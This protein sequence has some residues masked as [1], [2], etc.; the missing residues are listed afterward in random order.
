[1][2]KIGKCERILGYRF[3]R[4]SLLKEALTHSS[5]AYE[6]NLSSNE[7]MEFLGDAVLEMV[8]SNILYRRYPKAAEGELT[9]KRASLVNGKHL[10]SIAKKLSLGK[11]LFL[12]KGE[13]AQGGRELT[14]NLANG[15]EAIIGAIFLDG[16]LVPA[17]RFIKRIIGTGS[18]YCSGGIH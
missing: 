15:L 2:R 10:A 4:K 7:R 14:S 9:E 11:F 3:K 17:R 8:V 18:I 13:E 6:N 16:G 5:F 1:M 12:G